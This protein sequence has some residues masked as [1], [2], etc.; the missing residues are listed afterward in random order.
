MV[1]T[2]AK[3]WAIVRREYL[4][5]VRTKWFVIATVF[6]PII[7]SLIV[8][9]PLILANREADRGSHRLIILDATGTSLG[10]YVAGALASSQSGSGGGEQTAPPD[11]HVV[12]TS[13]LAAARTSATQDV[14]ARLASG[15]LVLDSSTV[16]GDSMRYAGRR[17]DSPSAMTRIT[18]AVRAGLVALRLEGRGIPAPALDSIASMHTPVMS[19]ASI[20]DTG[21]S[22]ATP[23]KSFVALFVAFLLYMSIVLYGQS[24]LSGVIEEKLS[25]VA[26]IVISSV[27]PETLLAGKVLGVTAVGI[28]QQIIWV[29]GSILIISGRAYIFGAHSG[30][31]PAAAQTGSGM[32]SGDFLTAI[33]ATPWSWVLVVLLFFVL[34]F[35]FYG[36]LYAAVGATVGSEQEARQA[37]QPVVLLIILSAVFIQPVVSNPNS[38]MARV[39]SLLP[40]SSP[41][42]MPLRMAVTD[43]PPLE[44]AA[45]ILI[46][47]AGC[48]AAVWL[49]ARIYRV[50]LLMYGKR[51]SFKELRRWIVA[52]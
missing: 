41:I 25:R 16:R 33:I 8:F 6:G 12:T 44:I 38:N 32:A 17:S 27:R 9:L 15:Y 36:S 51:P 34:G 50:G 45:S 5:R 26:E 19:A 39:M 37:S 29:V 13:G 46:L 49:A 7:F 28:T 40:F 2:P 35:T 24:I 4:E 31:A 1:D 42:L 43:V 23:A 10:R 3:L 22:A 52:S 21:K 18:Q 11:V 20:D 14:T 30:A 47:V 48:I